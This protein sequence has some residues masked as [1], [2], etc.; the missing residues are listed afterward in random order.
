MWKQV[1]ES[2]RCG[3]LRVSISFQRVPC[4]RCLRDSLIVVS[5]GTSLKMK[6]TE[7]SPT[8]CAF[9]CSVE[10]SQRLHADQPDAEPDMRWKSTSIFVRPVSGVIKK[11]TA[12]HPVR[13][14]FLSDRL[15]TARSQLHTLG[16]VSGD[17]RRCMKNALTKID[18]GSE[19]I[20]LNYRENESAG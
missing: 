20:S 17:F 12:E 4:G 7:N 2:G 9:Y 1:P 18:N 3:E 11:N 13:N 19:A 14:S 8:D 5:W 6:I 10:F 16:C 15:D